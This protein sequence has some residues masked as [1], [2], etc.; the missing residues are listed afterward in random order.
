[1]ANI[2]P[3]KVACL[4]WPLWHRSGNLIASPRLVKYGSEG[5]ARVTVLG[6]NVDHHVKEEGDEICEEVQARSLRSG[7]ANAVTQACHQT[8]GRASVVTK[9]GSVA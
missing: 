6:L 7:R 1:M 8:S 5:Q 4:S 3:V 2:V 9:K